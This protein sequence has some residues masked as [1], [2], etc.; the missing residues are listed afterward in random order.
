METFVRSQ[1]K[2]LD[3]VAEESR[4]T[5]PAPER[6]DHFPRKNTEIADPGP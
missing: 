3:V 1:K 6:Q 5:P 2:F 4:P